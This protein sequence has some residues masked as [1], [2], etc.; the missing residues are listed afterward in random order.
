MAIKSMDDAIIDTKEYEKQWVE[1]INNINKAYGGV[2]STCQA[3]YRR[4]RRNPEADFGIQ[5]A[6]GVA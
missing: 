5:Q 1:S 4:V 3:L 2:T 6:D